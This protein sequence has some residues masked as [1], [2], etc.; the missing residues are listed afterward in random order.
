MNGEHHEH[1]RKL[2]AAARVEGLNATDQAWLDAHL[3][4]CGDCRVY[5]ESL[6]RAVAAARSL[7]APVDPVLLETTR[8][9]LHLRAR[10][11]RE[12]EARMHGLWISCA[13][14]WVLGALSAPL[15]WW[16]F[17][18]LGRHMALPD[19]AWQTAFA[20]WWVMPAAATAAVLAGLRAR[21]ANENGIQRSLRR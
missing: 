9:R 4:S 14:S 16:G 17:R 1:A 20:F 19:L 3:E 10:E 13:L 7:Q 11:L 18:W 6:D 12:H 15:L 5:V 8:R 21:A 2:L